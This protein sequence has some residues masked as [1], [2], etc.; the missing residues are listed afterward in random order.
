M[1]CRCL[2]ETYVDDCRRENSYIHCY[3]C[4]DCHVAHC[5]C[6]RGAGFRSNSVYYR[7]IQQY[8]STVHRSGKMARRKEADFRRSFTPPGDDCLRIAAWSTARRSSGTRGNVRRQFQL[9]LTKTK[10]ASDDAAAAADAGV[11]PIDAA[12]S[13]VSGFCRALS[14]DCA[15]AE[16]RPVLVKGDLQFE[17]TPYHS[18]LDIYFF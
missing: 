6:S 4:A 12:G 15:A 2:H 5:T 16:P 9:S 13:A 7:E 8:P 10:T 14:R 1:I 17:Q 18:A 11:G 3:N